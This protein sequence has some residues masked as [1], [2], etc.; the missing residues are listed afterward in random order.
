M[1]ATDLTSGA[2]RNPI[3]ML[4]EEF[5]ERQRRGEHPTLSEYTRKYPELADAIADLFPALLVMERVKPGAEGAPS[6]GAPE[7]S[8]PTEFVGCAR[9]QLGDFRILR[10]VAQGGMGVVYEAV[11]ESLGRHVALKILRLTG[12]FSSAQIQRF[13]LEACSAGRLH[14]GNIVPVYGVGEHEGVHYYAM[15]FIHGHGVDAI[16]DDLRR[17]RGRAH[18]KAVTRLEEPTPTAS[19]V[20]TSSMASARSLVTGTFENAV[21]HGQAGASPA[22]AAVPPV[23]EETVTDAGRPPAERTG[24]ALP[25]SSKPV[26]AAAGRDAIDTSSAS[27]GTESQFYRS[28]ARIGVQV[29]DALA[30]AH[31]QGVL[32]R[33]IKPSNLLLDVTGRVWVTDFGLAKVEGSEGPTRTGDIVGTIRYMPPERFD[34]WSDR[35]SD[36]YSLGATLYEMLTLRPLFGTAA[37]SELI[38]KVLHDSPE[39]PRQLDPKIPRDLETIVLKAIA[40][41][42]GDRYATAQALGEDLE[43]FLEDRPILARRSTTLEQCWRWC[44]RNPGLA[45]ANITAALLT[46]VL[47]IGSTIS[48]WTYRHQRN[49]LQFEQSR[50]EASLH[51]AERAEAH[52]RLELGKS[53]LAEGAALQRT[54]LIGQRF[55]SLDRL[56]EAARELGN[57]PEGR[58][59]LPE[60]RDH[61][62][63][64]MGLT[65]LRVRW[66]RKIGAADAIACDQA[67]ERYALVELKSGQAVVRRL[68]DDRELL[69]VPLAEIGF[70][71]TSPGFSPDGQH[72]LVAYALFRE[73]IDLCDVWHLGRRERVLQER[74]RGGGMAFHPDGQRLVFAPPGKDLVV[75]D[76][77]ARRAVKRLPLD[78]R[79]YALILDPDGRRLAANA[80]DAPLRVQILDLDTGRA[81]ASWTDQAGRGAMSWSRD[82][83]LLAVGHDDGRVF[84]W[85]VERG[86]L[87]SVLQGHTAH[88]V[89]CQFAPERHLL[90]THSWDG[91]VRLW[92]AATGEPLVSAT[93]NNGRSGFAPDGRRLAFLDGP[94]LGVW[95]V[96]HG[97]DVRTLDPGLIGNRTETAAQDGVN[98]AEFSP[99]GRLAALATHG[100]VHLYEASCGRELARLATGH[101]ETVLFDSDGRSLITYGDCGLFRW[102]IRLDP[103]G[104]AE[105]LRVG[106]PEL[107]Q[108]TS[109]GSSYQASWLPDHRTLAMT[110]RANARVLLVD[111]THPHPALS[112]A[113]ALSSGSNHRMTSIAISPDGRWAAAGGWK[114]AG[115]LVWDLPRRRLERILPPSDDDGVNRFHVGFSPDG[116]WLVS[117]TANSSAPGYYFWEVGTWKRGPFVSTPEISLRAA[118]VF[119]P[120]GRLVALSV[121]PQQIRLAETATG[122]AIAHLSTLQPQGATPL[123]FSPDGTK[124]IASTNRKTAMMWELRRIRQQLRTMDLDW[125]QPPLPKGDSS[126][127]TPPPIQSIRVVGAV[128]E[129]PARRAAELAALDQ[130]LRADPAA[131]LIQRGW[132]RLRMARGPEALADLE[133]YLRLRPDDPDALFLLAEAHSQTNHLPAARATLD[134]Y[135]ARSPDDVDAR[136]FR[137]QVALKL[138][139]LREA[140]EDFTRVLEADPLRAPV[141][142]QRARVWLSLGRVPDALAELDE[143]I[144]SDPR[145]SN[146]HALRSQVHER[147]GHP[148]QAWSDLKQAGEAPWANAAELNNLAWRLATG[149]PPLRDPERAVSR[150]RQAVALAPRSAVCLNTLGVAL[151]RAG[152]HAEA[153]ATLERSLAAGHG[154]SDAFDLFFLAMA[155]HR[156]GQAVQARDAFDRAVRWVREQK[157]LLDQSANELAGFR[158]EA[159]AVLAVPLDRLFDDVFAH[160]R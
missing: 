159:Q 120:D 10:E 64:A 104:G 8:S 97:Q 142:F 80:A 143:L 139:L 113:R 34:G 93:L 152:K 19:C 102:P 86:R 76:L 70:W 49:D 103:D 99:D 125:E 156:L 65:D 90:A 108:E 17:L 73:E 66:Q 78:F 115:I 25:P 134:R 153:V 95:D 91:T 50:T 96:A 52:A 126:A 110:E 44:R 116:R 83:R 132:L 154:Q 67:L 81:L 5:I 6:G 133:Q 2:D 101:C 94:T 60:L 31:Q 105:A 28:V 157:Q 12:R 47:A 135:L 147:L 74:S 54:G 85:D 45:G 127:A 131:A 53:L 41:E 55:D 38:E 150:A 20:P 29:A 23:I 33:D 59:H 22:L 138:G 72:L 15:Q 137:G 151:Y 27:L 121:S 107:L 68:D 123:A 130:R 118:P 87:A 4:A 71:N 40:K 109:G 77:V 1:S 75:W 51:R 26:R 48:A 148:D 46:L 92:D 155:H 43:R 63:A 98:A 7:A 39:A 58:A 56:A 124:L 129:P 79:P 145:N 24:R 21:H 18:S 3:E 35:R 149:P 136:L 146:F 62:I 36:V 111:T 32:H 117:C 88:V 128:L 140:A 82:G 37:Q 100:G 11:Q 9:K 14:H 122:R 84:V 13:Q 160:P 69:R 119:S 144:R 158:A 42:P 112:R 141:R 61:A 16:V 89:G 30:Y 57:D 114:E 106:P